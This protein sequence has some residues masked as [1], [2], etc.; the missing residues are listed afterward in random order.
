MFIVLHDPSWSLIRWGYYWSPLV[1]F[2]LKI[3]V[4]TGGRESLHGE[5]RSHA[6]R[7]EFSSSTKSSSND[8]HL[9]WMI[10]QLY[11]ALIIHKIQ[12]IMIISNLQLLGLFHQ[13]VHFG[14][15][16]ITWILRISSSNIWLY[17]SKCC[18][19]FKYSSM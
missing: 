13:L 15:M 5:T 18:G 6:T 16:A 10:Y 7:S 14:K 1:L 12:W 4:H 17:L 9:L 19:F 8:H 2:S 11:E 3:W